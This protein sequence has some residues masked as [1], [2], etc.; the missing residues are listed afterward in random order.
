MP[1]I[2]CCMQSACR[3]LHVCPLIL[4]ACCCRSLPTQF[5]TGTQARRGQFLAVPDSWKIFGKCRLMVDT[6]GRHSCM[7]RRA[8]RRSSAIAGDVSASLSSGS[9]ANEPGCG[10]FAAAAAATAAATSGG[11]ASATSAEGD[12]HAL[13]MALTLPSRSSCRAWLWDET[14]CQQD[15][16][17]Q[18]CTLQSWSK[19]C[20]MLGLGRRS[21]GHPHGERG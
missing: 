1:L 6:Q 3:V 9:T 12:S 8:W 19:R 21:W 7:S 17:E 14:A 16:L 10:A 4:M 20:S 11:G 5:A 15:L 2:T 18:A 13:L